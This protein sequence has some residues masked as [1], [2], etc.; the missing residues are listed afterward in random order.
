MDKEEFYSLLPITL[1]DLATSMEG[2]R[3]RTKRFGGDYQQLAQGYADRSCM[4]PEETKACRDVRLSEFILRV[5]RDV[6]EWRER[7]RLA[8]ISAEDVHTI[9]ELSA[10]PILSR[11]EVQIGSSRF[12]NPVIKGGVL[13]SHT[14][15]TTGGGLRFPVAWTG[16]REQWAVWWRYRQWHG[17]GQHEW[18]AYLGGRSVVPL[19]QRQP[20]FWRVNRPGRQVLFSGYHL[21]P[22]TAAAYLNE[23]RRRGLK[24]IHGYPSMVSLLASYKLQ[25]GIQCPAVRWITTGAENLLPHQIQIIEKAFGVKPRQ[26]YGMAEGVANISECPCGALHVDEDFSAVEFIPRANGEYSIVGT[27]FTNPAFPLIRYDTGDI[28]RLS[29][30]ACPCGRPGRV[31]EGIDGRKEDYV[32]TKSGAFLGRMDH[33]F[34]DATNVREA[35]IRQDRKGHMLVRVVKGDKFSV[36]DEQ[37]LRQEILKRVGRDMDFEIDYCDRIERTKSGK[38]R[39]VVSSVRECG[40][41]PG[42][43][44]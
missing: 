14:S 2:L 17:I 15:G 8:G 19:T 25:S 36:T 31:V 28:A 35:Q 43:E 29:N 11:E 9:K 33:I 12:V 4:L 23:M 30:I 24:W 21:G 40:L 27:N 32:V 26:H 39:F 10:L 44:C 6:P 37:S 41:A 7:F 22:E 34:K 16:H 38:L 3:I 20:P 5:V 1:Q 18:C 13:W 42:A